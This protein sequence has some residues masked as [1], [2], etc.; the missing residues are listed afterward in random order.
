M[1]SSCGS[2]LDHL[3]GK[4]PFDKVGIDLSYDLTYFLYEFFSAHISDRKGYS[5]FEFT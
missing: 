1:F 2:L 3:P 5:S 4:M